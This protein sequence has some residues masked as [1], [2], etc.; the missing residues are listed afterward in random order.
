[1]GGYPGTPHIMLE[2]S[3]ANENSPYRI[4]FEPKRHL[5]CDVQEQR[6]YQ[7]MTSES[8]IGL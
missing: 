2:N 3:S 6:C 8:K 7:D 5:H 4:V 1:M